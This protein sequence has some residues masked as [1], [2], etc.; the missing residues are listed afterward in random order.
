[1]YTIFSW[2]EA[3][4]STILSKE[5]CGFYSRAA[6]IQEWLVFKAGLYCFGCNTEEG[7]VEIIMI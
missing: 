5:K 4:A 7:E 3:V 1:M 6:C 2:I